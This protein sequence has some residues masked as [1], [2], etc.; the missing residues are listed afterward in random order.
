MQIHS[1]AHPL[2]GKTVRIKSQSTTHQNAAFDGEK[3]RIEDWAEPGTRAIVDD[4]K[5]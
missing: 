3:Y 1:S 5:W 2:A 4:C